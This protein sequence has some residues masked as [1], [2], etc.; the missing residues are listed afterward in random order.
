MNVHRDDAIRWLCEP[1]SVYIHQQARW[2]LERMSDEDLEIL[3]NKVF[4][5]I[6]DSAYVIIRIH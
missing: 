2:K 1:Q 6:D 5:S 4:E 3:F